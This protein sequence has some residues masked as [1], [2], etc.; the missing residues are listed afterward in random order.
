MNAACARVTTT[1]AAS[2]GTA[3]SEPIQARRPTKTPSANPAIS[4]ATMRPKRQTQA[5]RAKICGGR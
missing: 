2:A 3:E 4:A 5:E 1:N